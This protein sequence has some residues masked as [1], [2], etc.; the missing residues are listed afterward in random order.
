MRRKSYILLITAFLASCSL[1]CQTAENT[2]LT[3]EQ[4]ISITLQQNPLILSS[5]QQHQASLAR[6][7]Q[8]KALPQPSI[9]YDSDLQ[10]KFFNFKD[11][12]ESYFGLSQSI[13]FP[14]K[15]HLRGKIASKESN[16]IMA[17]I[18]LLKLDIVFHV[19]Q[20]FYGLLLAQEKLKYAQQD[21]ELAQDFLKK[22][23][24]K[25]DAGDVAKVEA[26][27]A[28]VESAKAANE[29]RSLT[30]EVRLAKAM[31]NFLLARKK[32]APLEIKGKLKRPSISL[33][34]EELIKRALSF[35]PEITRIGYSLEKEN[36]K[37]KQGYLSYLPDFDLGVS[38][39]RLEGEG[40]YWDVTLSFPIPLFFW[41]PKKG[42]IREAQANVEAL[43]REA[44]HLKNAITLEVEEAYMNALTASNMIQLFEEEMLTQAEEVYNMFLFS[45]QEGEIG[46]IELIEARRTLVETRKSYADA[47]YHYDASLAALEKS[48]G[49]T[50]EGEKQ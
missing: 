34:F 3:L 22:A 30:N 8:A 12:G 33:N 31:L 42:E 44:E 19:K 37:K 27:R 7:S 29:V 14:G 25:F 46:G 21:L 16:E 4:C 32:Y 28:R 40:T 50:L 6:I 9:N 36:L 45:Y 18:D 41:Q 10:P 2:A 23:E 47:L 11:S 15:R 20:A 39:H 43:K 26:L 49:Q 1:W 35:R 48:I 13:E 5:L 24:L 38:R 17:E